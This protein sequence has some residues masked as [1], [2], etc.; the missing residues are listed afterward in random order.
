MFTSCDNLPGAGPPE[1]ETASMAQLYAH[2]ATK[3]HVQKDMGND[4][5]SLHNCHSSSPGLAA[6]LAGLFPGS[7]FIHAVCVLS[8]HKY[9]VVPW[10]FSV[11]A[12][13]R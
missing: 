13:D 5:T 6:S 8:L 11:N 4:G 2:G 12:S 10:T 7:H 1:R 3:L 9:N